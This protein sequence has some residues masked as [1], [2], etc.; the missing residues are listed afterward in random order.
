MQSLGV[1][2]L[3]FHLPAVALDKDGPGRCTAFSLAQWLTRADGAL[4]SIL[5]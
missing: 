5:L 4:L 3:A 1:V 2:G